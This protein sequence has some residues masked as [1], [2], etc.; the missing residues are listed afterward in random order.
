MEFIHLGL[1]V[2]NGASSSSGLLVFFRGHPGPHFL[3]LE[4]PMNFFPPNSPCLKIEVV[5]LKMVE[6][7]RYRFT[8]VA[9]DDSREWD[10]TRETL[11]EIA[12]IWNRAE[13]W[14]EANG[15]SLYAVA[16]RDSMGSFVST[17]HPELLMVS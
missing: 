13:Q 8:A 15:T 14:C 7:E 4:V 12:R 10:F 5:L 16:I 6:K 17:A 2:E 3:E 1:P 9:N 11:Q